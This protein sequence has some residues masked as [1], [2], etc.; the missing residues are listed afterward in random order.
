VSPLVTGPGAGRI[1]AGPPSAPKGMALRHALESDGSLFL[2][3]TRK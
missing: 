2:R 3:Y 1:T